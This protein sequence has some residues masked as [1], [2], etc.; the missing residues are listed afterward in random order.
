MCM[1]FLSL[2]R[3]SLSI[4]FYIL[5][6]CGRHYYPFFSLCDYFYLLLQ[7]CLTLTQKARGFVEECSEGACTFSKFIKHIDWFSWLMGGSLS[8][9]SV[10]SKS[11]SRPVSHPISRRVS[12]PVRVSQ[13]GDLGTGKSKQNFYFSADS[14][15]FLRGGMRWLNAVLVPGNCTVCPKGMTEGIPGV[16][17]WLLCEVGG[18]SPPLPITLPPSS[19]NASD[20]SQLLPSK[21]E[22]NRR[23]RFVCWRQ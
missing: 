14:V 7:L 6:C 16:L 22:G 1:C 3:V 8:Q 11:V 9:Q 17:V 21:V 23:R 19:L 4:F 18:A 20:V 13:S 12:L 15:Y 5:Y 2:L 10:S